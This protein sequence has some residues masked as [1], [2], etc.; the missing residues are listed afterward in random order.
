MNP[1]LHFTGLPDGFYGAS[2]SWRSLGSEGAISFE[3]IEAKSNAE[4]WELRC[5]DGNGREFYASGRHHA[6]AMF[7][8][9]GVALGHF[10][11]SRFPN[12][13]TVDPSE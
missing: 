8:A 4:G 11:S 9:M 3:V 1:L 6:E 2:F 12:T 13:P 10:Q 7:R 5:K